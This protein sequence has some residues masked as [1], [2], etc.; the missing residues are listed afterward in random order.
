MRVTGGFLCVI[1]CITMM[2]SGCTEEIDST[3]LFVLSDQNASIVLIDQQKEYILVAV[4]PNEALASYRGT[5]MREG[6]HSDVFDALSRL[7]GVE[8]DIQITASPDQWK[9]LFS[10]SGETVEGIGLSDPLSVAERLNVL[11]SAE[12]LTL[13]SAVKGFSVEGERAGEVKDL[14]RFMRESRYVLRVYQME[15]FFTGR[16]QSA[17]LERNI[18]EWLK[19]ARQE[20]ELRSTDR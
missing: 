13:F 4:M 1:L 2:L 8:P 19:R 9:M 12:E 17:L 6:I 14:L 11:K 15:T 5:L 10:L 20:I 7:S 3:Q 18:R 16:G